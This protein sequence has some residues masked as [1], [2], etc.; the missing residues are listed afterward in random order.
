MV[1]G[2][3]PRSSLR[4]AKKKGNY[5]EPAALI[6]FTDL[7]CW[8]H[9]RFPFG[10]AS[11]LLVWGVSVFIPTLERPVSFVRFFLRLWGMMFGH[12][13]SF[14]RKGKNNMCMKHCYIHQMTVILKLAHLPSA[15]KGSNPQATNPNHRLRVV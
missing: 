8:F 10:L 1:L 13:V 5:W 3:S 12:R 9:S 15:T 11:K 7:I 2:A 4:T 6:P 14:S